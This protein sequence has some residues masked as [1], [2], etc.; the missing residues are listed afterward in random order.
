MLELSK[1]ELYASMKPEFRAGLGQA[2]QQ[3]LWQ[4]IGV[5]S[6]K[7]IEVELL[8]LKTYAKKKASSSLLLLDALKM[9]ETT[10]Q[11]QM[12]DLSMGDT[13]GSEIPPFIPF[14][15]GYAGA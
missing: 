3:K 1:T 8:D 13:G 15:P 9:Y 14:I 4:G 7:H 2:S 5:V 10:G 12:F 11:I 6:P